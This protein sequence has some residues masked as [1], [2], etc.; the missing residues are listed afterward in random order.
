MKLLILSLPLLLIACASTSYKN[1]PEPRTPASTTAAASHLQS[2]AKLLNESASNCAFQASPTSFIFGQ[3]PNT[4]ENVQA[5]AIKVSTSERTGTGERAREV[6]LTT[7]GEPEVFYTKYYSSMDKRDKY[8]KVFRG[9]YVESKYSEVPGKFSAVFSD[10][11]KLS[12]FK[13]YNVT[14]NLDGNG[15]QY[16]SNQICRFK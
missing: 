4:A 15:P 3:D 5:L 16:T 6:N 1:N 10:E 8:T 11:G 9:Y 2:L 14:S 7:V 12:S 13:V